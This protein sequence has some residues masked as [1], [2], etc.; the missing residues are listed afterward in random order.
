MKQ[1]LSQTEQQELFSA[2]EEIR[3]ASK[4]LWPKYAMVCWTLEEGKKK[5]KRKFLS[6]SDSADV[7]LYDPELF[8]VKFGIYVLYEDMGMRRMTE[9]DQCKISEA[10][11]EYSASK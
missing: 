4:G 5:K 10:A 6:F 9:F 11:E 8:R 3:K 1:D 7:L 2:D